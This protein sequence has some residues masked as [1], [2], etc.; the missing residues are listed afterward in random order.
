MGC[1]VSM[2]PPLVSELGLGLKEIVC[3]FLIRGCY[4]TY[5]PQKLLIIGPKYFFSTYCQ[6]VQNSA[7]SQ[8]KFC[9]IKMAPS[10][11]SI[12]CLGGNLP[13]SV[14]FVDPLKNYS[15]P[16]F[17]LAPFQNLFSVVFSTI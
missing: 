13:K 11:T 2:P 12:H 5:L 3:N 17:Q 8:I 14:P 9:S 10:A 6:L 1:Q 16:P 15:I 7:K 4:Y